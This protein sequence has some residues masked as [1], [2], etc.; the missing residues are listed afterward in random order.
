MIYAE[1]MKQTEGLSQ[2][3]HEGGSEALLGV[4]PLFQQR[5]GYYRGRSASFWSTTVK[6]TVWLSESGSSTMK[7]RLTEAQGPGGVSG[8]LRVLRGI[9]LIVLVCAHM[10]Q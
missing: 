4:E 8:A 5:A 2:K 10:S 3:T 9:V 1:S 6:T 7:C